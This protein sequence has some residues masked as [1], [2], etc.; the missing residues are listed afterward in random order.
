MNDSATDAL[1]QITRILAAAGTTNPLD[2]LLPLVYSDLRRMAR[3]QR[4][5]QFEPSET[6]STTALVNEA[7]LKLRRADYPGLEG[8]A[9]FFS[10]VARAMRQILTDHARSRLAQARRVKEIG[11]EL[12]DKPHEDAA[13]MARLIEIDSALDELEQH[14][15]RL[16]QVVMYRYFAGHSPQEVADLLDINVRTVNRDWHKARAWLS[17]ALRSRG[18]TDEGE[19]GEA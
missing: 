19:N 9:H 15:P 12:D 6:L 5:Q 4:R 3:A 8:R 14:E 10:L 11:Y 7:Y 13:E 1:E 16:A 2:T 17:M 18:A